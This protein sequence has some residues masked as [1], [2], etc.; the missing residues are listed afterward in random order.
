MPCLSV[1]SALGGLTASIIPTARHPT[2]TLVIQSKKASTTPGTKPICVTIPHGGPHATSTTAF[3]P[4]TAALALEGCESLL[5]AIQ[6]TPCK[7]TDPT[8]A[9]TLSLPNYTGSMGFGEKYIR[10]LLGHCGTMDVQDVV[11]SVNELIRLG[12]SEPGRQ[13]VQGGS[14]GG[15]LAAHRTYPYPS[16]HL[17]RCLHHIFTV[18]GQYPDLF[19][20]AVMRNPVI[21]V[22]ELSGSD[23]P[24]WIHSEFG[25]EFTPET[26]ITP[27]VYQKVFEASPIAHID[28]VRAP[29]LLLLGED[30][31]R[32]LP[33]QGMRLYH[34]LKG[35]ERM[36][37]MLTFPKETHVL[38]GVEAAR[39][40]WEAGRDWFKAFAEGR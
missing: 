24:D 6:C 30:D 25:L 13:V 16:T 31:M 33:T 34:A 1:E 35:R 29:V 10:K 2:E 19:N 22:G 15:F 12:I 36:V 7:D 32:V 14:H 38:D 8:R 26:L 17:Q 20:A 4:A 21:S 28:R 9:D 18:I 3:S 37:E 39:V 40:S 11:E 5:Q 27:A 23:I